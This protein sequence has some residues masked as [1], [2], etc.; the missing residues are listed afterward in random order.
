MGNCYLLRDATGLDQLPRLRELR[1]GASSLSDPARLPAVQRLAALTRLNL[2]A[3]LSELPASVAMPASLVDLSI[4]VGKGAPPAAML[5]TCDSLV[6]LRLCGKFALLPSEYSLL[7]S[8]TCLDLPGVG[9]VQLPE[10]VG[11]LRSLQRLYLHGNHLYGLPASVSNLRQL[12]ECRLDEQSPQPS[13]FKDVTLDEQFQSSRRQNGARLIEGAIMLPA[14][15][16]LVLGG[17]YGN[18]EKLCVHEELPPGL[19]SHPTLTHLTCRA[20]GVVTLKIGGDS[21]RL[22]VLRLGRNRIAALPEEFGSL[23][24]L[25]QLSLDENALVVLPASLGQ[26][27]ALRVLNVAR[28]ELRELPASLGHLTDLRA[29]QV[30]HNRLTTLPGLHAMSRLKV[31]VACDN[32]IKSLEPICNS[33]SLVVL[34][35]FRNDIRELPSELAR[36]TQ[37]IWLD[38]EENA[39]TTVRKAVVNMALPRAEHVR[40]DAPVMHVLNKAKSRLLRMQPRPAKYVEGNVRAFHEADEADLREKHPVLTWGIF[41]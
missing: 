5:A 15:T 37:L 41:V 23:Q 39:I 11:E 24:S 26:L 40:M 12:E 3:R 30:D 36:L 21:S 19:F 20:C 27:H 2:S 32:Q 7:P 34:V 1:L 18:N 4:A 16:S 8:L 9:L 25:R 17:E 22:Q 35:L 10:N 28:N 13:A 14:M 29:L 33:T 31:L 6:S 38:L